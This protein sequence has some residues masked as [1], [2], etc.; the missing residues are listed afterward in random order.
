MSRDIIDL[1]F[2]VS[3]WGE[4]SQEAFEIAESAYGKVVRKN[5]INAA[6]LLKSDDIYRKRCIEAMDINDKERLKAGLEM[7]AQYLR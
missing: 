1:A 3:H 2:M 5:L 4:I 6:G 7:I